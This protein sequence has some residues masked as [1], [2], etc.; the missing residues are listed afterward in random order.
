V[1]RGQVLPITFGRAASFLH[2][3]Q[4]GSFCCQWQSALHQLSTVS[5]TV[6]HRPGLVI[7][8][9]LPVRS[10]TPDPLRRPHALDTHKAICD[11]S[12]LTICT[13]INIA[14]VSQTSRSGGHETSKTVGGTSPA[15]ACSGSITDNSFCVKFHYLSLLGP[16]SASIPFSK[17]SL[18]S[19][20]T[21]YTSLQGFCGSLIRGRP[22][23]AAF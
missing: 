21:S 23:T 17:L 3:R 15:S 1:R 19:V 8:P 5:G 18:L 11:H 2:L 6:H 14:C 22:A 13:P 9:R 4:F 7:P 10:H 16:S 20:A 12:R